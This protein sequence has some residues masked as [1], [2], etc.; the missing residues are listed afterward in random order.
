MTT[1]ATTFETTFEVRAAPE[2]AWQALVDAQ[3]GR[4]ERGAEPPQWWLPGFDG[5]GVELECEPPGRL[6]LRK[7]AMPCLDT[8]IA[9]TFEHV[10]SGTR[11][12][13]VQ[14][15]FDEGF[16]EQAGEHFWTHA[17]LIAAGIEAFFAGALT[18]G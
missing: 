12:T 1:P 16:V 17:D 9:I 6:T 3:P 15:G 14:S 18:R 13:V 11:I 2:E 4:V 10:A 7:D 5:T 8:T